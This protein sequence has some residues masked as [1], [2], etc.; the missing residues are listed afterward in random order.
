MAVHV[1]ANLH[2][3]PEA[4]GGSGTK[5]DAIFVDLGD[6]SKRSLAAASV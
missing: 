6:G 4:T 5:G 3:L 2:L 1:G